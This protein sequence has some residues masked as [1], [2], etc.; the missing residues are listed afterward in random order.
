MILIGGLCR[1]LGALAVLVRD[2]SREEYD[3]DLPKFERRCQQAKSLYEVL[4]YRM[5]IDHSYV[6]TRVAKDRVT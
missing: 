1:R 2:R 5:D 6:C 3:S 4:E